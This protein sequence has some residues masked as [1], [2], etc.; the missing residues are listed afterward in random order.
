MPEMLDRR[1][2]A[3][4]EDLAEE[5]LRGLVE[6]KRFVDGTPATI[7]LPV[8]PLR[9]RPDAACGTDTELLYGETARVLDVSG[10]WAWVK[11]DLDGYVG[12]VPHNA[13]TAPEVPAS[14]I[15][16][17]PRTFVY[18]GP[19][20]RFPQAFALSMGS[21]LNVV[22]EAETRGTRYFL[23][24]G[25]LAVVANHC[26]AAGSAIAEDYVSIAT[27]FFETPYLWGGRS[28]FGIDCSGLVQLSMQMTGRRVPRDTDMQAVALGRAIPRDE[29]AR[30]DLVFWKGHVAIMEDEK[31]L[32]H[33]NGHTMT[34]AR[35]GLEDA[36]RRISWLYD[37]PTGYRRP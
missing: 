30:G 9:A 20:L 33:A 37:Q 4:R 6:A 13:V 17:V 1:L 8:T 26:A 18:R 23:L 2:N 3:Y 35:E 21:R 32:V 29:L 31:T 19:D 11:S 36:I 27:R 22:G 12:Y 34:V 7:S 5:R 15:V 25:G 16:A 24:D 10:G 14:H 28:G